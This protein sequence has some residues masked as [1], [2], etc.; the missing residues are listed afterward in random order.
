MQGNFKQDM[1]FKCWT[2]TL[3]ANKDNFE[4]FKPNDNMCAQC[5]KWW[6]LAP[7]TLGSSVWIAPTFHEVSKYPFYVIIITVL[8]QNNCS[9]LSKKDTL[10]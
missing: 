10:V 3:V 9:K 2:P 6:F 7:S 5:L 8:N 4:Y 1:F